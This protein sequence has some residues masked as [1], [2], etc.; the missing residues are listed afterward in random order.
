[1]KLLITL[2]LQLAWLRTD[3]VQACGEP[4]KRICVIINLFKLVLWF[5][6]FILFFTSI[7]RL[8]AECCLLRSCALTSY[9][10]LLA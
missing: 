4:L 1:M 6:L 5:Q 9:T 3:L 8:G 2:V 10:R 7:I